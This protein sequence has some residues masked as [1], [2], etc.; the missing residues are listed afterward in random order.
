MTS[1]KR[2]TLCIFTYKDKPVHLY[3]IYNLQYEHTDACEKTVTLVFPHTRIEAH[4]QADKQTVTL[5]HKSL[6]RRR[7]RN[8]HL[9]VMKIMHT[10]YIDIHL[11]I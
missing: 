3:L 6:Y 7:V 11:H 9:A 5:V 1:R 4:I 10:V 8:T 2:A